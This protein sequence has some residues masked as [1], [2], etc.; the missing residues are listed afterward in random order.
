MS[1]QGNEEEEQ[2]LNLV[3]T[4]MERGADEQTRN[5]LCRTMFGHQFRFSLKGGKTPV[6]T[7]RKVSI[8]IAFFELMFFI[9][10]QTHIRHLH[11]ND[12][13]IWDGNS[14]R[15]FLD[16]RGLHYYPVGELGPIYGAQW[17]HFNSPFYD[18]DNHLQRMRGDRPT[19][20]I[21]QLAQVIETLKNPATRSSRRIL[22]TA[23]N[24][25]QIED[26]ALPPCHV[27]C[28]FHV[29]ENRYLSC[30]LYQRS[31]DVILGC[32]TNIMCYSLLTHI[33][34]KHCDL[35]ADEF[36]HFIGNAHIYGEHY[37]GVKTQLERTPYGFPTI[38]IARKREN[39]EDYEYGD[40]EFSVPYVCH[41]GIKFTMVA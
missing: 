31:M 24:P 32:P 35:E 22:M 13:H 1:A 12:I 9:R 27:M 37:G 7:T 41:P 40:I 3:R 10:G 28:Q 5:G 11:E 20:G 33:L 36:V 25:C 6:L 38:Q 34:A 8:R 2:Y 21:D 26:M 17:R 29:R 14:T 4:I 30:S 15:E 18:M 39:I 23:W 16:G 19:G